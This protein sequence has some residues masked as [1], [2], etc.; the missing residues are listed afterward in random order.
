MEGF[1]FANGVFFILHLSRADCCSL[2]K[3]GGSLCVPLDTA[4]IQIHRATEVQKQMGLT[5]M[6]RV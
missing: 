5:H 4:L 6:A 1:V 3:G 2:A